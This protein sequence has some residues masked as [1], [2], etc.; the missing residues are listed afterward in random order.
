MS[1]LA[2]RNYYFSAIKKALSKKEKGLF[3]LNE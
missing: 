1:G 2:D 3:I